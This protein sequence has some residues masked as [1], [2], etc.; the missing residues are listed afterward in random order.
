MR[1]YASLVVSRLYFEH[2]LPG[3]FFVA[4]IIISIYI[5]FVSLSNGFSLSP[6]KL[7]CAMAHLSTTLFSFK[8]SKN[9]SKTPAV[10]WIL[11]MLTNPTFYYNLC[12]VEGKEIEEEHFG[13]LH[14][15]VWFFRVH[16]TSTTI[17][18][19]FTISLHMESTDSKILA[20]PRA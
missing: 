20:R 8:T 1:L 2:G 4:L 6:P 18:Y 11:I 12:F 17:Y 19:V 13:C 3:F 15:L 7:C 14:F 10:F 9:I 5:F 16:I